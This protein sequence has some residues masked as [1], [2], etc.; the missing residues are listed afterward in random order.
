M[1]EVPEQ[2]AVH[3]DGESRPD[4]LDLLI[5]IGTDLFSAVSQPKP[6]HYPGAFWPDIGKVLKQDPATVRSR[7]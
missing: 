5:E 4:A 6:E 3:T 1:Q 2:S 7:Q